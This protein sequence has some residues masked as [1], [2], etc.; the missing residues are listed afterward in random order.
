LGGAEER[1]QRLEEAVGFLQHEQD[2]LGGEIRSL[3][4][5]V[6]ELMK[7]IARLKAEQ[8]ARDA[9]EEEEGD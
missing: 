1:V 5:R 6:A 7:E 8:A 4:E 2:V 9:A 3:H